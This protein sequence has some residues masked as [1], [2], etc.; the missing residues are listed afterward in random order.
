MKVIWALNRPTSRCS[1]QR[2]DVPEKNVFQRRDVQSNVATFQRM[3]KI[4]VAK[5]NINVATFQRCSKS[6]SRRWISTSRRSRGIQNERRN[7]PEAF[8]INVTTLDINVA[9]F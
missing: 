9:T 2:H 6:T 3:L 4:N 7:I 8:K 1:G 5:L